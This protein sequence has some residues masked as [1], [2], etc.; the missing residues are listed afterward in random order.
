MKN[1]FLK[2]VPAI[3]VSLFLA[4]AACAQE[5]TDK[6]WH[7]LGEL[8]MMFPNMTGDIGV[9]NL[10]A[11][12]VDAGAGDILGNLEMGAMLY[13]EA[14]N[15]DWA[16]SSDLLYMKLGQKA[17]NEGLVTSG[18]VTM[19]QLA[20]E[21]AG[22]KR[23]APW[24]D[25]GLAGRVVNLYTGLELETINEPREGSASKTWFDPVIVLRSNNV[26]KEKWLAQLRLDAGGF[27]IGSDFTWQLQ[28]NVGYRFSKLF[29]T[30][31]GYRYIGIDYDK[32]EGADRFRYDID[33]YGWVVRFG[34]N[35]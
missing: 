8:Y 32:G 5:V 21:I 35:F 28:A 3:I 26:L 29:Q 18:D 27:S 31:V 11:V 33:T 1:L 12:A 23:V 22:L 7:Y 10:P 14:T 20:W 17:S 30:T 19:K 2:I 25:A 16:I 24:L 34:F 4:N 13:F 15:D 9:G 6:K